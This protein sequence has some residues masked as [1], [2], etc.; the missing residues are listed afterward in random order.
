MSSRIKFSKEFLDLF[1]ALTGLVELHPSLANNELF[2]KSIPGFISSGI[3]KVVITTDELTSKP[4]ILSLISM[5]VSQQEGIGFLVE[6]LWTSG[7]VIH[8]RNTLEFLVKCAS[9]LGARLYVPQSA[10]S[11]AATQQISECAQS[12]GIGLIPRSVFFMPLN[13]GLYSVLSN[14]GSAQSASPNIEC[15]VSET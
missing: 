14:T 5:R 6:A 13:N 12:A 10:L 7:N 4:H 11:P 1:Q 15:Y 9:D 2:A 8:L 3:Y